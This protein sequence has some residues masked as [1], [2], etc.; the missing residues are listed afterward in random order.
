M[1]AALQQEWN[2][3]CAAPEIIPLRS[4]SKPLVVLE[5]MRRLQR[6]THMN[7]SRNQID[8]SRTSAMLKQSV[9]GCSYEK[10]F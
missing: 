3:A 7:R 9:L 8:S 1:R 2:A 5:A 10:N 6:H 4:A